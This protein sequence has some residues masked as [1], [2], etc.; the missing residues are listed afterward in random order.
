MVILRACIQ[1]TNQQVMEQAIRMLHACGMPKEDLDFI[2][3]GGEV[4]QELL[5]RGKPR[6]TQFTGACLYGTAMLLVKDSSSGERWKC[7]QKGWRRVFGVL[8]K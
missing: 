4:M 6:M 8:F 2:N 5:V 7:F 1:S 3:C